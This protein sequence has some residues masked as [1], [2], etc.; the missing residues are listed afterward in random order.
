MKKSI[1]IISIVIFGTFISCENQEPTFDWLVGNWQRINDKPSENTYENWQKV[2]AENYKGIGFTLKNGDTIFKENLSLLKKNETWIFQVEG[3]NE[4]PVLFPIEVME[5][6]NFKAR[7]N[8][9][10]FPKIIAYEFNGENLKARIADDNEEVLFVF[11][12]K[13]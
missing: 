13:K 5:K 6:N 12:K 2:A 4:E 8:K 11:E 1:L 3:V 7:N 10:P 9:N